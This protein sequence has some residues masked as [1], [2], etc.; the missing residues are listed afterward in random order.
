VAATVFLGLGGNLGDR[1]AALRTALAALAPAVRVTAVS[2]LYETEPVGYRE[3][4]EFLNAVARGET[5]LTPWA[6]LQRLKAIERD[7]GREGRFR[8]APRPID[9]DILFFDDLTLD[10]AELVIP[11]P[12]LAERAFTLVPL[13]EIAPDLHHPWL[14]RPARELLD[15]LWEHEAIRA[16][17][18]PVWAA[19]LLG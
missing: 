15:A 10:D 19:D 6:L 16:I 8:N 9:L 7:L 1:R 18:G 3:Q 2:S 5:D 14:G 17:E 12:R 4:P 11:H 13:V